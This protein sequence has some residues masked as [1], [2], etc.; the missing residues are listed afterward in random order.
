MAQR[1]LLV[2]HIGAGVTGLLLAGPV[3]L[4]PK[5]RGGHTV[6]G[7]IYAGALAVLCLTAAPLALVDLRR[8]VGLLGIAIGTALAGAVGVA[9][10]RYR[11]ALPGGWLLW[12]LN[13]MGTSVISLVTAFAVQASDG[14]PVSWVLPTLVGSPL[15]A[16]RS[17]ALR[18]P[19][20]ALARA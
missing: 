1:I 14:H 20:R 5:R 3:V 19:R 8:M 12:H 11:P 9:A 18:R 4:V 10:A 7:R 13:A 15:I 2:L 16:A 6:L 17:A